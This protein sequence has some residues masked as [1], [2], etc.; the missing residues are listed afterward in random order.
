[1]L[2]H[3]GA[4]ALAG[5]AVD[6]SRDAGVIRISADRRRDGGRGFPI[7]ALARRNSTIGADK[8]TTG[9][10]RPLLEAAE[11]RIRIVFLSG[12]PG[13]PGHLFRIER[14]A[15]AA[16]AAGAETVIVRVD[17]LDAHL[18]TVQAAHIIFIWRTQWH[19]LLARVVE[20]AHAERRTVIYD[21]DDLLFDPG[22]A[23]E[24]IIDGIRSLGLDERETAESYS[25]IL[26]AFANSDFGVA[27]TDFLAHRMRAYQKPVFTLPNG[28]DNRTL[29]AARA[30][31]RAR[32]IRP[33]DGVERIGYAAGT[34]THQRDFGELR[35]PSPP[36]CG[37]VRRR[38]SS[39]SRRKAIPSSCPTN[40]PSSRNSRSGSNGGGP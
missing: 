31:V 3:H 6:L 24:S 27:P 12:D 18:H 14:C 1:M 21:I 8:A 26:T 36:Y 13:T 15:A 11:P 35:A 4:P 22:L 37:C 38:V 32:S 5:R 23:K 17:E 30:A 19:D 16:A 39:C 34:R 20:E 28:F 9:I 40:S 33:A 10:W 7:N 2:A 29:A 25:N